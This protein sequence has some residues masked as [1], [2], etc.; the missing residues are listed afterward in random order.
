MATNKHVDL[1]K[2]EN[3]VKVNII[4]KYIERKKELILES[5]AGTW[6]PLVGIQHTK[7]KEGRYL[8][9]IENF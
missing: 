2:L 6:K 4:L 7:G 8:T 1:K 3:F 9:M 5:L